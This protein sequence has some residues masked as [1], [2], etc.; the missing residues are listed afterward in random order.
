MTLTPPNNSLERTNPRARASRG[1][2]GL[3]LSSSVRRHSTREVVVTKCVVTFLL[4]LSIGCQPSESKAKSSFGITF[5][6][7]EITAGG[8]MRVARETLTISRRYKPTGFRYGAAVYPPN[9]DPYDVTFIT[10]LPAPPQKLGR[11][12]QYAVPEG[13]GTVI[14][15]PRQQVKG[16]ETMWFSFDPG[17]PIG[18]Y[19]LEIL[20]NNKSLKTIKYN[21]VESQ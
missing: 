21:V 15:V 10:R 11:L 6:I 20:V 2:C 7:I 5:G 18:A 8:Q 19:S 14:K 9:N 16:I 13:N 1:R 12:E 3:P 17:D 4:L